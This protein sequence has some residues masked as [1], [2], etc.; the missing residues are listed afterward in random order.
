MPQKES[1][2]QRF[3]NIRILQLSYLGKYEARKFHAL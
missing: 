2:T 3:S 1:D